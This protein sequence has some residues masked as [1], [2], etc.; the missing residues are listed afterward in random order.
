MLKFGPKMMTMVS[1]RG[2]LHFYEL[3]DPNFL[4]AHSLIFGEC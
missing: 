1:R 2:Y 4:S 3:Y